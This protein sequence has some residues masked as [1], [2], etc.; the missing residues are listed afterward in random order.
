MKAPD[1]LL[2]SSDAIRH[3]K[4]ALC[5]PC[6]PRRELAPGSLRTEVF[7]RRHL[8]RPNDLAVYFPTTVAEALSILV[9]HDDVHVHASALT[10]W[11][12]RNAI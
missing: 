7:I 11:R 6:R 3:D 10:E 1:H 4:G 2:L 5:S 12:T 9:D 8:C